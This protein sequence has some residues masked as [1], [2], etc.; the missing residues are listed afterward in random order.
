[1]LGSIP[2][3]I[4]LKGAAECNKAEPKP[5]TCDHYIKAGADFSVSA[6]ALIT[7]THAKK[8]VKPS[9]V[10]QVARNGAPIPTMRLSHNPSAGQYATTGG[11]GV[12]LI[13][14]AKF[15]PTEAWLYGNNA[16]QIT[17]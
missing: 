16:A 13:N 4:I 12:G 11:G 3:V 15:K 10:F 5:E 2:E 7:A 17:G 14:E 8:I 6:K 9:V 1:M